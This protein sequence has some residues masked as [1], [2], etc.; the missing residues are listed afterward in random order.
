MSQTTPI[1]SSQLYVTVSPEM[2]NETVECMHN[3]PTATSVTVG[4]Y[5]LI[6]CA[7]GI[8]TNYYNII[9]PSLRA[10]QIAARWTKFNQFAS[11]LTSFNESVSLNVLMCSALTQFY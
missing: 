3:T 11:I 2:H 6:L 1:Y 9:V 10:P 8:V 7:T 5:T 4:I